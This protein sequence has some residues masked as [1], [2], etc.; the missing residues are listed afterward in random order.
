[1]L[2]AEALLLLALDPDSGRPVNS[3]EQ[4]LTPCLNGALVAELALGGMVQLEGKRFAV[5]GQLPP[6]GLLRDAHESLASPKGRRAEDQ[7]R[8]M[9]KQVDR[10]WKRVVDGLVE[11]GVLDRD[12]RGLWRLTAHPVLRPELRDEVVTRVRAAAAGNREIEPR[13]AVVL[14][15]AGP[16]RLLEVVADKP[17]DHAKRRIAEATESTPVAGVVKKVIAEAAAAAAAATAA[18]AGA[19]AASSS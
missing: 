10:V 6:A 14:A 17:H 5:T 7:L 9:D 12:A 8:R 13:T 18:T 11:R 16:A 19:V 3:S 15:L 4:P 1:M 2:L